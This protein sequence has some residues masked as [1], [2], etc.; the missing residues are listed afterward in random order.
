MMSYYSQFQ[1]FYHD[2]QSRGIDDWDS[3]LAIDLDTVVKKDSSEFL[4]KTH[5]LK[6]LLGSPLIIPTCFAEQSFDFLVAFCRALTTLP[7][8]RST[9]ARSLAVDPAFLISNPLSIWSASIT[10][11]V[12]CI[13]YRAWLVSS[14]R[15]VEVRQHWSFLSKRQKKDAYDRFKQQSISYRCDF[16]SCQVLPPIF[17]YDFMYVL[18][19]FDN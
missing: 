7:C 6:F 15:T 3:F 12:N 9:M 8:C 14:E 18:A 1:L 11:V 2:E 10:A 16:A 5:F 19:L 13:G 4:E 17:S